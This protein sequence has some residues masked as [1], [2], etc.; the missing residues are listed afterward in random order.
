MTKTRFIF[1]LALAI[2]CHAIVGADERAGQVTALFEHL[3]RGIQPGAAVMVMQDGSVVYSRGFGYADI[4]RKIRINERSAFRLGSVSKQFTAMA[5]MVLADTGKL[6]YDDP[7]VDYLP[8]L[9]KYPGVTV[10][11]LLTHTAGLP[12]YY[13]V[14]DTSGGM[15][16]NA[17]LP[18]VLASMN[19]P[20]NAPG[21]RH[22]YS[23]PAYELLALVVERVTGQSF[24]QFVAENVFAPA[25]MNDTL[26]FDQTEPEVP[27][28][29][30]GYE[31]AGDGFRPDDYH[32]LNHLVGAGGV[33][34]PLDDFIAWDRALYGENVVSRPTLQQAFT[35]HVLNNGESIDYGFGWRI[36]RY[37]G[38]RRVAHGG[39][40]V[41]F[42]A[43]IA[44]Y[45]EK[46]LAI[47]VLFNR[48]D[49]E[50]ENQ[51]D[52]ISDIFLDAGASD[53]QGISASGSSRAE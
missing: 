40:W 4:D 47:V 6:G 35:R 41:G 39:S 10:R 22:E 12:D 32:E 29:V 23:N 17:D 51:V 2:S 24:A 44:R 19:G 52:A 48:T 16:V 8:Q 34:A 31:P 20:L 11:H 49:G 18:A 45:P 9:E 26:I 27:N 33:Y 28:R 21:E 25:G 3:D 46:K 36:D 13:D 50:P 43:A 14:I 5:V 15:P 30:Y 1:F 37:R 53:L 38:H 7:V 42:R